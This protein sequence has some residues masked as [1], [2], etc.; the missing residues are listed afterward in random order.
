MRRFYALGLFAFLAG[1]AGYAQSNRDFLTSD[2]TDQVREAQDPNVRMKLYLHF[3]KQRLDQ[4]NQLLSKDKAGRSAM[5]HDLLE[6]YAQIIES[7]DTVADDALKRHIA[8][9][10]G[11]AAVLT[12]E[13][14]MLARLQ[15]IDESQPKDMARYQF[16]LQQAIETT[17]DSADLSGEDLKT[18]AAEVATKQKKDQT[19][20]ESLMTSK[21]L[22]EKKAADKAAGKDTPPAQ[23]KKAPSLLRPGETAPNN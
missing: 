15:K 7:I 10:V 1:M 20:R 6:D 18:R 8:I 9:D 21:E 4:V 11:N 13:K 16:V 3:A 5:V 14:E 22:A 2:E 19:E 12:A 23:Q 17:Q